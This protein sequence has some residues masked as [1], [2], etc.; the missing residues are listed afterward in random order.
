MSN[1]S[2][3]LKHKYH[4]WQNGQDGIPPLTEFAKYIGVKHQSVSAW[5]LGKQTPDGDNVL[6]LA[7]KLGYEVYEI[8]GVEPPVSD[9]RKWAVMKNWEKLAEAVK[10]EFN[11]MAN[12]AQSASYVREKRDGYKTKKRN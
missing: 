5:L 4:E 3:W 7:E 11:R 9:E 10:D 1:F 2:E 12:Q 8:L 6:K